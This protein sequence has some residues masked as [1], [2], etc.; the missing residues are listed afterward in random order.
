MTLD[1]RVLAAM[2]AAIISLTTALGTFAPIAVATANAAGAAC[3]YDCVISEL[4]A[5]APATIA[6]DLDTA[7]DS[8]HRH[9]H[10]ATGLRVRPAR[11]SSAPRAVD[12]LDWSIVK[13]S[14]GETRY[15]HVSAH[16]VPNIDKAA[17][18]VFIDDAVTTTNEAWS[19]VQSTGIQP[20]ASGG[21]N[22]YTVPM[23][24]NVGFAGGANA[25]QLA[26]VPHT[27]VEI[28]VKPGTTQIITAYPV[29]P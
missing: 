27:S 29:V 4:G 3:S 17:H 23:G 2:A 19:I 6:K 1:T 8:S 24:R 13:Q 12:D 25:N 18:G 26:G 21:V 22:V 10:P 7:Q 28:I 5:P 11:D 9:P 20:V 15:Q 14:T 16:N